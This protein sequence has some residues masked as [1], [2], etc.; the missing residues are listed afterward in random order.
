LS[1]QTVVISEAHAGQRIDNYLITFFKGVPRSRLYRALRKGEVRVNK[2]RVKAIYRLQLGDVLRLPPLRV[3]ER[4]QI[5]Q[6]NEQLKRTLEAGILYEDEGLILINKPAGLPVH[7]GTAV[8]AGLIEVLRTMRPNAKRLELVHRLDRATSGCLMIAKKRSLLTE[9]HNLL[10]RR[11]IQKRYIAL[12]QG[13]WVGGTRTIEAPLLKNTLKSGERMVV[14]SDQGKPAKTIFKPL[15]RF[16]DMTLV[17][18]NPVTGRTHQIRV[19]AT[20][21]GFPIAG[22]DKYG[23]RSF[24]QQMRNK[25]LHR[26]F[27]HSASIYAKLSNDRIIG[28]C[29]PLDPILLQVLQ[30]AAQ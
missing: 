29:A 2:K 21:A 27:L 10:T 9:L 6:P 16:D 12:V 23:D 25:G 13:A 30:T 17:E 14:V 1:V 5:M 19:H 11:Q 18:A 24:N 20:H 3:A 4:T 7:G 8:S 26:L 22:D 28:L 15:R